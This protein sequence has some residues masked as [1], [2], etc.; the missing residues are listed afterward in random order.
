[1]RR[2]QFIAATTLEAYP[3]EI[4]DENAAEC[5]HV[6]NPV[7]SSMITLCFD[8]F[9]EKNSWKEEIDNRIHAGWDTLKGM[10]RAK[11]MLKM[12][13][14]YKLKHIARTFHGDKRYLFN[15]DPF[16]GITKRNLLLQQ[17]TEVK[18]SS[19]SVEVL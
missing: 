1:M 15:D 6:I 10:S 14:E 12:S 5:L 13:K 11:K 3:G 2:N 4:D 7:T 18:E 19:V 16:D 17:K 8:N 9:V